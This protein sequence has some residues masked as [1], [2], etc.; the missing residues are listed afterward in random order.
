MLILCMNDA[1]Y[2]HKISGAS[3]DNKTQPALFLA[4]TDAAASIARGYN[5]H[6]QSDDSNDTSIFCGF[7]ATQNALNT[8]WRSEC[9]PSPPFTPSRRGGKRGTRVA[10]ER[11]RR[12][13]RPYLGARIVLVYMITYGR[14]RVCKNM[15]EQLAAHSFPASCLHLMPLT[16]CVTPCT[17]SPSCATMLPTRRC[18]CI[19]RPSPHAN[20]RCP[21]SHSLSPVRG[22]CV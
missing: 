5:L 7:S 18:T 1:E 19:N 2:E 14:S 4:A 10:G 6:L 3:F 11:P 15:E 21:P 22:T 12:A 9:V 20:S 8:C 16:S 17:A 13:Y